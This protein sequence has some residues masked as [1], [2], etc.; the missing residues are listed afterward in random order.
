MK[1]QNLKRL[2][3][4]VLSCSMLAAVFTGCGNSGDSVKEGSESR[5]TVSVS[6][7]TDSAE[8]VTEASAD[9]E[10]DPRSITEGVTLTIAVADQVRVS[11]WNTNATT[12]LVEEA[13]GVDLVFE[14]YASSD[15]MNKLTVMVNGGDELPDIIFATSSG[16]SSSVVT[17]WG[18]NGAII[19][20]NE[21][22]EN[23]DY[24]KNINEGSERA[25]I[26]IP[27]LL[28]N[29]N[30][31]IWGAPLY[32]DQPTNA[33][34][35]KLWINKAY[36]EA[37]GYETIPTTTEDFYELCKEFKAAGDMNGNG[38]DD[39]V[40]FTAHSTSTA[41]FKFLMSP[42]VYAWDDY[43]LDVTDGKLEF[44]YTTDEWKEGLKYI[45]RF[46]DE[47]IIDSTILTND[48]AAYNAIAK[49]S[50]LR[51][52]AYFDY[53]ARPEGSDTVETYGYRCAYDHVPALEGSEGRIE[54][55]Y[56]PVLPKNGAVISADCENPLAAF[57]VLDYF[58]REDLSISYRY[59][60]EGV[61]W[62]YWENVDESKM[63]EGI[64]KEGVQARTPEFDNPVF[65][66]YDASGYWTGSDPQNGGYLQA[67]P[68]IQQT[69]LYW[70]IGIEVDESTALGAATREYW[71]LYIASI[72][73]CLAVKPDESVISLPMT[74]EE[75]VDANEI[76]GNLD[77]YITE[78]IGAFLTGE[79]DIDSYW[80]TYLT[81]LEKIGVN[82]ALTLYQTSYDRTVE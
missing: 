29:V 10:F 49:D 77:S 56:N 37:L 18:D 2:L 9:E 50:S 46:F 51:M 47:G 22:Y 65:Y 53:Y 1:Y 74:A 64:A 81:E 75:T 13:L 66:P 62:D 67:G 21:Y 4:A 73:D 3:A 32:C 40:V 42:F 38:I 6:T 59:G 8:E 28:K 7:E 69:D 72:T 31:D 58:C 71:D 19:P 82:E 30:G 78:S 79:W 16:F 54:S 68:A 44:A 25:G 43:Y 45:K 48:S 24:A 76:Q 63:M 60:E 61:D 55:R 14:A 26:Y 23:P 12:L 5:N 36:A 41:W 17:D 27:S 11:D 80:D 34:P 35:T 15:Y 33:V 39:E 70:G 20:L 52:L 57:L